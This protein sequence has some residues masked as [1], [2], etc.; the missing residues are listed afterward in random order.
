MGFG[1]FISCLRQ[2][3]FIKI[4]RKPEGGRPVVA[5]TLPPKHHTPTGAPY[6]MCAPASVNGGHSWPSQ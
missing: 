3:V 6:K 2:P 5:L 1:R 4:L